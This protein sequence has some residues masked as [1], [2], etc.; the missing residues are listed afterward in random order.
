MDS[1][2]AGMCRTGS[3]WPAGPPQ[4]AWG[5]G[6]IAGLQGVGA[7]QRSYRTPPA[8]QPRTNLTVR[9]WQPPRQVKRKSLGHCLPRSHLAW[10]LLEASLEF[11][12]RLVEPSKGVTVQ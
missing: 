5:E 3:P 6:T 10:L 12:Y 7:A 9:L 11:G 1:A 4:G 2:H 8:P